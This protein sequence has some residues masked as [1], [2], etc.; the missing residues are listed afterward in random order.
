M[1]VGSFIPDSGKT[2]TKAGNG[3]E[4]SIGLSPAATSGATTPASAPRPTKNE[5]QKA[6]PGK[7]Y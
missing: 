3:Q 6:A 7:R 5:V 2:P 1:V 4:P